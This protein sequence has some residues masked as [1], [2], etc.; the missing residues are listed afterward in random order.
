[1]NEGL[2]ALVSYKHTQV[3][4]TTFIR[5]QGGLTDTSGGWNQFHVSWEGISSQH[6]QAEP[7]GIFDYRRPGRT[8]EIQTVVTQRN[9]VN[10]RLLRCLGRY[11][12]CPLD[13]R[14][15]HLNP[16]FGH[17]LFHSHPLT[18]HLRSGW[19][20]WRSINSALRSQTYYNQLNKIII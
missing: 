18:V 13:D 14:H 17:G 5:T 1:M 4:I 6:Q 7:I 16:L 8:R 3:Y 19:W 2:C 15:P 10:F 9:C 11:T 20:F 12:S